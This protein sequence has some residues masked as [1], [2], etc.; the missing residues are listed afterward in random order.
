MIKYCLVK[1][2]LSDNSPGEK[3]ENCLAKV[4]RLENKSLDHVIKYMVEEGSGLTRHQAMAYFE[5]LSQAVMHFTEEGHSV[6]TPLFQ[7]RTTISGVF[8]DMFD[9]FDP[10]RHELH[11]RISSGKRLQKFSKKIKVKKVSK[12]PRSPMLTAFIDSI[13]GN[14]NHTATSGSLGKLEGSNLKFDPSD[15]RQ[16]VFFKSSEDPHTQFRAAVYS[17]I[18]PSAV[19]LQVPV[20]PVGEYGIEIR[21]VSR[22]KKNLMSDFLY[23]TIQV[24]A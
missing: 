1:N 6:S 5:R 14:T 20:L 3:K 24:I 22:S 12:S 19:H 8:I 21:C 7:V 18:T 17:G 16:G 15:N 2:G 13:N 10:K 9:S 11:I 4:Y 23:E